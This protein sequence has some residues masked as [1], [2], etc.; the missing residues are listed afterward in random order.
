MKRFGLLLLILFL[1]SSLWSQKNSGKG[2]DNYFYIRGM[3]VLQ[4]DE[5]E[6]AADYF[7]QAI[8]QE[9]DNG[10]AWVW[11]GA[12]HY[13]YTTPDYVSANRCFNNALIYLPK[14][15]K[16]M[17]VKVLLLAS[18]LHIDC[19]SYDIAYNYLAEAQQLDKKNPRVYTQLGELYYQSDIYDISDQCYQTAQKYDKDDPMIDLGMARNALARGLIPG[20]MDLLDGII[21][22]YND[23]AEAYAYR[24]VA[25]FS[26]RDWERGSKDLVTAFS[27]GDSDKAFSVLKALRGEE[28]EAMQLALKKQIT[29]EPA[30]AHWLYLLAVAAEVNGQMQK[31]LDNYLK[32]ADFQNVPDVNDDLARCCF[33]LGEFE[34]SITH[35]TRAL[36]YDAGNVES[37]HYRAWSY[38]ELNNIDSASNDMVD[39]LMEHPNNPAILFSLAQFH[40]RLGRMDEALKDISTAL[41]FDSTSAVGYLVRGEIYQQMGEDAKAR[42]DFLAAIKCDRKADVGQVSQFAY[43]YI[44]NMNEA[45]KIENEILAEN[46]NSRDNLADAA[47]FYALIGDNEKAISYLRSAIEVGYH[48]KQF[49]ASDP[50]FAKL[51]TLPEFDT[52][53]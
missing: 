5:V 28:N 30:N 27:L 39:L 4:T 25:Y 17:K 22:R 11:L 35:S 44:G 40:Q 49:T 21:S 41:E 32:L 53:W 20:A 23:Y 48:R 15:D 6:K 14:K 46:G 7:N 18:Q 3:E 19:G 47:R 31:A 42:R 37:K 1:M 51:R 9:P 10:Y 24:A 16:A 52:M 33:Y 50:A 29:L 12:I 38:F 2:Q 26:V 43:F 34:N 8:A 13:Y 45:V 36:S